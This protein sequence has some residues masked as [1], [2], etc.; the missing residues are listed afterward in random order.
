MRFGSAARACAQ[1][2]PARRK[3]AAGPT[4]RA[5]PGLGP[6]GWDCE[7][8][9]TEYH[10]SRVRVTPPARADVCNS[11]SWVRDTL[12]QDRS[13]V[14]HGYTGWSVAALDARPLE[15]QDCMSREGDGI[16]IGAPLLALNGLLRNQCGMDCV[17][18]A[19]QLEMAILAGIGHQYDPISHQHH[20]FGCLQYLLVRVNGDP[21][22]G[23]CLVHD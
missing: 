10:A 23:P 8:T 15:P 11:R 21:V 13:R 7:W 18:P 12:K 19:A 17:D 14:A 3:S 2:R 6:G 9:C 22:H 20:A 1:K 5:R 16:E 4:R